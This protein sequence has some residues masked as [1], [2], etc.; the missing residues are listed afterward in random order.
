MSADTLRYDTEIKQR[1]ASDP[2]ASAFVA[3]NAGSGKTHVLVKRLLRL[4]VEGVDPGKILALTYTTAAAANMANR[5]FRD[6]SRWVTLDD[7][8]LADELY[9]LDQ[10]RP[11]E[12]KLK[13]ARRL[14]ARAVETPGGLKIQTI[15]AF[16]ERVL[17]LF[18]FEA[19]VPA[20]FDILDEK[21]VS[22][23]LAR[24]RN[25]IISDA[26]QSNPHLRDA[27]ALT[28]EAAGEFKFNKIIAELLSYRGALRDLVHNDSG[29]R[30]LD[31]RIKRALG[32]RAD[33]SSASIAQEIYN[34]R[35]PDHRMRAMMGSLVQSEAVRDQNSIRAFE[36]AMELS[37]GSEWEDIYLKVFFRA[38]GQPFATTTLT[39]SAVDKI[40]PSL[41]PTLV[42]E[43]QRIA[44]LL[45]KRHA[46]ECAE[47]SC[48][49]LRVAEAIL[50]RYELE[51]IRRS[52]L[53]Q[54]RAGFSIS[55]IRESTIFLLMRRKIR[56]LNSGRSFTH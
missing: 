23:R 19:N 2:K 10:Q 22:D 15:H 9:A 13:E 32:L 24:A 30:W 46:A 29:S 53:A 41:R 55:L 33:D 20:G 42:T 50:N 7:E 31:E 14:F 5:V 35:I 11:N 38:D 1:R 27:L 12:Q 21:G 40:D 8:A 44:A 18:P 49:A 25:D 28:I 45:K 34:G 36:K 26:G 54:A 37:A 43:Q 52:L 47:R 17:H 3:A 16:C 48:A 6:L 4:L 56:V 39:T 51:K